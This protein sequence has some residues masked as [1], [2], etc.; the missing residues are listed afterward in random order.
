MSVIA[1]V[2]MGANIFRVTNIDNTFYTNKK[3]EKRLVEIEKTFKPLSKVKLPK[4]RSVSVD[5]DL[6]PSREDATF[7]GQYI[8][9][10]T[11][12]EPLTDLWIN[13]PTEHEE[14]IRRM[15]L[16]QATRVESSDLLTKAEDLEL[17]MRLYRFDPPLAP[18]GTTTLDFDV[19]YHPPK[20]GDGSRI[21]KK[22]N[23]LNNSMMPQLGIQY[24][25]LRDPDK[26]RKYGLGLREKRPDRD[27]A[28]GRD[29][30]FISNSS[31]FVDFKANF[32]TDAGQ[33]PVAPGKF[34][35]ETTPEPGR[36]CR[37]YQ[38]INPILNFFAFVS[39]PFEVR[40][41]VW[42]NPNG[43]DVKL[44]IYYHDDH[45]FNIDA[46]MNAM[47]IS[48]DVYTETFGPYQYAQ[49]RIL[50][51]PY[52]QFAQ[53]FAGTIPFSEN[54]GFIRDIEEGEDK[55]DFMSYV[56]AHELG[57]QWFA[58]QIVPADVKGFNVLSEGLTEN[59]TYTAYEKIKGYPM[60]RR[61]RKLRG[62]RYLAGRSS[63]KNPEQPLALAEEQAYMFYS[64]AS[65]AFLGLTS[66]HGAR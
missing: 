55:V 36:I 29:R 46:M 17:Y 64:K 35:G 1:F 18:G 60:T 3:A 28:D 19:Y 32:C 11:L 22:A 44:V 8:I 14:D 26:R 5:V 63:D 51:V 4:V 62:D 58:H 40:E 54:M 66:S 13:M 53:A 21:N 43:D 31:D 27:D 48:M 15:D 10:N 52:V 16:G 6:H 30:H 9:E 45:P 24:G 41:D 39:A 12:D 38:A 57:H 65:L 23:F 37:Q 42:E 2:G 49:A 59:A 47:Q 56:T 50:E 34:I 20:F 61:M 25:E 33:I 7:K